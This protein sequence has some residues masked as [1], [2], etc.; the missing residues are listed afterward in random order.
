MFPGYFAT[1]GKDGQ[2]YCHAEQ[3]ITAHGAVRWKDES[4]VP[5]TGFGW[6]DRGWGRRKTEIMWDSG[7]DLGAALLPDDSV[8]AFMALR[9]HEIDRSQ[10]LPVAAWRAS[11]QSLSPAVRGVYHKDAT[12]YPRSLELE[13]LDGYHMRGDQVKRTGTAALAMQE[14]DYGDDSVG[15]ATNMRDYYAVFEDTQGARFPVYTQNG[16]VHNINVFNQA[17]FRFVSPAD[18]A[19]VSE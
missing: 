15:L 13:F 6:R 9:S 5:F 1:G 16:H 11:G 14:P 19:S 7:W 2:F 18:V 10:P 8:V 3:V 4:T 12:A 17:D